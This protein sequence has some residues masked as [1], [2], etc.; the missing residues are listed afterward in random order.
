MCGIVGQVCCPNRAPVDPGVLERM[1]AALE[2]RGPDSRGTFVDREVSLGIQRLRVV[3]LVTGDQ[4]IRNEDGSVVVVLN[5][6]IYN[7]RE[8]REDLV[9]RGHRFST[10]GDTETIVHLYEEHGVDCVRRLHGMFAFALWDARLNQ[11]LLARDRIGKKPLLYAARDR[12]L[13]F[14]SE[15]RALMQSGDVTRE[16]DLR[17]IDCYLAYGYVPTPRSV[18]TSVRKLPPAHT[19]VFRDGRVTVERYWRLDYSQK[20]AVK[21]PRELHEPIRDAIR[22]ATRRR[23]ISDVP[24]GAFLSGGIDSSAVVAAMAE[25]G[26][27]RPVKTFSIGF[28]SATHNELPHARRVA[29]LFGTEHHEFVVRPDA[30]GLVPA[31]V[32][33]YGE[34]FADSSAIPSFQLAE[35]TRQHVTVALNGD[36]GDESFGG[37]TRYVANR[38]AGRLDAIPMALRRAA[39]SAGRLLADGS[40]GGASGRETSMA[41]KLRRLTQALPLDPPARYARYVSWFDERQRAALYTDEFRALIGDSAAPEVI[42]EPWRGASGDHVLDVMLEV[43]VTTYLPDDLIAKIDIA[44]MA[45]ALEAR[46]PLLDHQLM[47]FAA[48]IP[49]E[50]K[51]KGRQKKW[52]MREALRGWLPDE[53]LD[54]PKQGFSL[55]V[56]DWFRRDL[57]DHVRDVLLDPGSLAR[58]YFRPEAIRRILERQAAGVD[59]ESKRVWALFMLEQWHREFVDPA[60]ANMA[61]VN[62]TPELVATTESARR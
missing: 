48:S 44:T 29:E 60:A 7:F 43:D 6:E 22:A 61:T 38:L 24:L 19:L 59:T 62:G 16:I 27:E 28:E 41:N 15:M 33:H 49:T 17:A 9:R 37:Y 47:E 36:G 46:S 58:G 2:H 26:G 42:G 32:R 10:L 25:A 4:P 57:R 50:L 1:C 3:D 14:A 35:L 45:Y 52:I 5:G 13:S 55:P 23:L 54:R 8:L 56:G 53:I 31:I 21:D 20:L 12:G 11:L 30:I 51:V 18:F 34:P 40:G 39:A